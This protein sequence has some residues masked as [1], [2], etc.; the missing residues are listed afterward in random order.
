MFSIAQGYTLRET[1]RKEIP[2]GAGSSFVL[3]DVNGSIEV[4]RW[5][6][7]V[8]LIEAEKIV[9]AFTREK[10]EGCMREPKIKIDTSGSRITIRTL[11]PNTKGGGSSSG[12]SAA[13]A[14]LPARS[15][16][17]SLCRLT[18]T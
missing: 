17:N 8:F 3:E 14:A 15:G 11:M 10:A 2:L 5:D 1:L 9:T 16:I 7:N 18:F 13:Y 12:F 6:R 4:E